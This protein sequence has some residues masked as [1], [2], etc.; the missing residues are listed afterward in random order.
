M[1]RCLSQ[2]YVKLHV[3]SRHVTSHLPSII[4]RKTQNSVPLTNKFKKLFF[5]PLEVRAQQGTLFGKGK[6]IL[7]LVPSMKAQVQSRRVAHPFLISALPRGEWWGLRPG[8]F[9]P[10]TNDHFTN[11]MRGWA[12][13]FRRRQTILSLRWVSKQECS[14]LR[15]RMSLSS[16]TASYATHISGNKWTIRLWTRD[17]GPRMHCT[18]LGDTDGTCCCVE[19]YHHK[20]VFLNPQI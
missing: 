5:F 3:T 1:D 12:L 2:I 19:G 4:C 16:Q 7:V 13:W 8:R 20:F 17:A 9:T 6:G 15:A 10:E 11:W 18:S 14:M